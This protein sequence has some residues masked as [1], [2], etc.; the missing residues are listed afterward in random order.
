MNLSAASLVVLLGI[1][2]LAA[3]MAGLVVTAAAVSASADGPHAALRSGLRMLSYLAVVAGGSGALA[4]TGLLAGVT[5]PPL[6]MIMM[7]VTLL[8]T[9]SVARSPLGARI[10]ERLPLWALVG[11][12]AFRLPLELV[13]RQAARDGVMPVH[14]S[15]E[16]WNFDIVTGVTALGLAALL[17]FG[18]VPRSVVL[19]WNVLGSA[20]LFTI[21]TIAVASAPWFAAFGP[22]RVNEFVLHVPYVWLATVLVPSALFGHA[23]V[24]RRLAREHDAPRA[25]SVGSRAE[26]RS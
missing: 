26:A 16:G 4:G 14:M 23:L 9:V 15:F 7:A 10:A 8:G 12:Q 19:A 20:L 11:A 21:V 13:M 22:D 17:R 3:A 18:S 1:S 6:F 24:Y 5:R 25:S 2:G